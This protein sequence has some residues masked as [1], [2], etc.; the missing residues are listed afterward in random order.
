MPDPLL[1]SPVQSDAVGDR[2]GDRAPPLGVDAALAAPVRNI[3]AVPAPIDGSDAAAWR[4]GVEQQLARH[5]SDSCVTKRR[6]ELDERIGREHL[7]RIREDQNVV[8]RAQDAGVQRESFAAGL[9]GHDIDVAA[10]PVQHGERVVS[11]AIGHDDD[12]PPVGG[13]FEL[14]QIVQTGRETASLG[15]EEGSR[16][17]TEPRP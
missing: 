3:A 11:R 8:S 9:D 14:Q 12:L 5:R 15:G 17:R 4:F 6:R 10:V 1:V 13:I 7:S 16:E 2:R